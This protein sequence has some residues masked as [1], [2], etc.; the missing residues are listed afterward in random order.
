MQLQSYTPNDPT[1]LS[2]GRIV[3]P[4]KE[5]GDGT[6]PSLLAIFVQELKKRKALVGGWLLATLV[7]AVAAALLFGQ[8][9]YRGEGRMAYIPNYRMGTKP[10]YNPPNIQTVLQ[11][12]K[13]PDVLES[14]RQKHLP[15]QSSENFASHVRTEISKQSEYIDV[16]F[17]HADRTLAATVTNDVMQEARRRFDQQRLALIKNNVAQL[18]QDRTT[19]EREKHQA[20]EAYV[21]ACK[22]KGAPTLLIDIDIARTAIADLE[23]QLRDAKQRQSKI[24]LDIKELEARRDAPADPNE[25]AGDDSF[26]LVLQAMMNELQTKNLNAQMVESARVRLQAAREEEERTRTLVT[27]GILSRSDYEK[28]LTEIRVN[29]AIVK[30]ADDNQLLQ[31]ALKKK[32]EEL[33]ARALSGKPIRRNVLEELERVRVEK[34][35]LPATITR[36]SE[37]ITNKKSELERLTA[38]RLELAGE[39]NALAQLDERIR[40]YTSQLTEAKRTKDQNADDLKIVTD[41]KPGTAAASSNVLKLGLAIV[42]ASLLL[43]VGYIGL[44]AV[45]QLTAPPK[46]KP[47]ALVALVPVTQGPKPEIAALPPTPLPFPPEASKPTPPPTTE[48]VPLPASVVPVASPQATPAP[49]AKPVPPVKIRDLKTDTPIT[50]PEFVLPEVAEVDEGMGTKAEIILPEI[51]THVVLA[52]TKPKETPKPVELVKPLEPAKPAETAKSVEPVKPVEVVKPKKPL[53]ADLSPTATPKTPVFEAPKFAPPKPANTPDVPPPALM[54]LLDL[55][56]SPIKDS[57]LMGISVE[58]PTSTPTARTADVSKPE[59]PPAKPKITLTKPL[60]PPVSTPVVLPESKP[61]EPAKKPSLKIGAL[62]Q[63]TATTPTTATPDTQRAAPAA[64]PDTQKVRKPATPTTPPTPTPPVADKPKTVEVKPIPEKPKTPVV[65]KPKVALPPIVPESKSESKPESP[66]KPVVSKPTTPVAE[67]PARPKLKLES[68][69]P[70]KPKDESK[71]IV[72][73]NEKT[74]APTKST[75]LPRTPVKVAPPA[76]SA[77]IDHH[78]LAAL[79]K[80]IVDDP[81]DQG[82]IVLFAPT[83]DTLKVTTLMGDMSQVFARQGNRV[84][85]F[86]ARNTNEIPAWAGPQAP[87]VALRVESFLDGQSS[88]T[89]QCFVPTSIPSVEYSRADVQQHVAGVMASHRFRQ[90]IEEMRERYSIV[91]MVTPTMVLGDDHPLLPALAEG[92]VLVTESDLSPVDLQRMLSAASEQLPT[93]VYGALAAPKS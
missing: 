21:K 86:D 7:V 5:S 11:E 34:A 10:L 79:A 14:V 84:L 67:A 71:P 48:A 2:T 65:D 60:T 36:L 29:E 62:D 61:A 1:A 93:T 57:P 4:S 49:E 13:A 9:Q 77:N 73:R 76:P 54:D 64:V 74:P 30:Q 69:V 12:I 23:K 47:T 38:L 31:S 68:I 78:A 22:A 25:S 52:S 6:P 53:L 90:L 58:E 37:E 24:D 91:L 83:A 46:T 55:M 43:L 15:A 56:A 70:T 80:R 8:P 41:A 40:E 92:M 50:L 59:A 35:T 51:P 89:G 32:Y 42:G 26:F 66:A 75:T 81:S 16:S 39:E 85:V 44:F 19:A 20:N 33:K 88:A 87:S 18:E 27:R 82:K 28:I 72:V 63:P 45:P 3:V 17:D